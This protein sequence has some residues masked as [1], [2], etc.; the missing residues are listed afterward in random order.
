[1]HD[2][3]KRAFARCKG[4][5][6][7]SLTQNALKD[8][9]TNAITTN[10]LWTR[11]WLVEPLPTLVGDTAAAKMHHSNVVLNGPPPAFQP[12]SVKAS[13]QNFGG[14]SDSY[15]AFNPANAVAKKTKASKR[16]QCVLSSLILVTGVLYN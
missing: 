6:D 11:N 8:M 1:M 10:S 15:I 5:T 4:A 3:V 13:K 16:K 14:M 7:Q 12:R 2:Y 9:I